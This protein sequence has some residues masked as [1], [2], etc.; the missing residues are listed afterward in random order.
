[1]KRKPWGH[2]EEAVGPGR[3]G[4]CPRGPRPC[5]AEKGGPP[6]SGFFSCGETATVPCPP[7]PLRRV[8]RRGRGGQESLRQPLP[9]RLTSGGAGAPC[10]HA[11]KR[12]SG[13]WGRAGGLF[14][15]ASR[16]R[17]AGP[18]S[19]APALSHLS[20]D[21]SP[22]VVFSALPHPETLRRTA[23]VPPS[24]RESRR[25]SCHELQWSRPRFAV[26][27]SRFTVRG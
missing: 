4:G 16:S 24:D 15:A 13:P 22:R 14:L 19:P 21:V 23:A 18:G 1:M 3:G 8:N 17:E 9:P 10:G 25:G 5:A 27:G 20:R 7:P 11:A 6:P 26:R 12:P 2:E